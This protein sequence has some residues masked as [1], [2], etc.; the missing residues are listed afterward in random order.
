MQMEREGAMKRNGWKDHI[1][2]IGLCLAV[3][4]FWCQDSMSQN[5][6][7]SLSVSGGAGYLPL[8]DWKD[9][10]SG[11]PSS[12]F[13]ED[14]FGSYLDFHASY[15]LTNKHALALDVEHI[16][17][18]AFLDEA[19]IQTDEFGHFVGYFLTYVEW[20]FSATPVGLSYEFY[21]KGRESDVSPFLGGGLDYFFS[22][23][24]GKTFV[25]L[26][27]ITENP[28]QKGSRTGKGYGLHVYVGI[29]S[30]LTDHLVVL[31]R[32]RG[33]YADGMGFTD[34]PGAIKVE[35]TGVDFTLGL[36]WMF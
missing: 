24:K 33:R 30:K 23:V 6:K 27:Q 20:E 16:G 7:V 29:E 11:N 2:I 13:R 10:F 28:I 31:S 5:H 12:R 32:F 4:L 1:A 9:T 15:F 22:Q 3:V 8:D 19:S 18:S 14:K 21:P 35:F 17:V 34:K 36:G 26:D 25:Y